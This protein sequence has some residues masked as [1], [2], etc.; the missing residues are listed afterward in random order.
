MEGLAGLFINIQNLMLITDSFTLHKSKRFMN[1]GLMMENKNSLHNAGKDDVS[2]QNFLLRF[3]AKLISYLFHPVFV[4]VYVVIF[5][6]YI[7]PYLFAGFDNAQKMRTVMMAVVS[8]TFFPLITVLLLKAL[9]FIDSIYLNKQKE[10][11]IPIIACMTWYF[12]VWYV[13]NNF[14]KTNDAVDMP[15]PIIQFAFDT[16]VSTFIALML[17]IKMKISLHA[18]SMGIMIAFFFLLAFS[19]ELNFGTWLSVSLFIA[20]LVCTAR[21]I[22]SDHTPQEVYGGL[23]SGIIS[24]AIA[25]MVF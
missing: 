8:F 6:V 5:M 23:L 24:M 25:F 11:I 10:R 18:I 13:W 22:V 9:K 21:F 19:Q 1:P 2:G 14:G 17:N 12:W 3:T 7:H 16:F 4:P 20:G 15:K